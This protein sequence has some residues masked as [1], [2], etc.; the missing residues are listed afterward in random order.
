DCYGSWEFQYNHT[1][2]WPAAE[3]E[4]AQF[5]ASVVQDKGDKNKEVKQDDKHAT[6]ET[7]KDKTDA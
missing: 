4:F 2:Y 6:E 3:K 5:K 1:I 7:K